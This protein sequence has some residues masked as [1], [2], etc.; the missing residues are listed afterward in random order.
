MYTDGGCHNTGDRK[1][2]GS[3][4]F[5]FYTDNTEY[6]DVYCEYVNDTTNNR[7]EMIAVIEGIKF[8]KRLSNKHQQV[9]IV[10]DSGY[11]VKGWTD[12][13][14]LDRW[15]TNN[16]KTSTNT[17]VQNRDLWMEL[18]RLSWHVGFNFIHIRGHN[19]D[20]NPEHA[21]WNDICDRAC[22][23]MINKI[24]NPGFMVTLRYYFK[25]RKFEPINIQL[26]ERR[27]NNVE[28]PKPTTQ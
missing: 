22:T 15:V 2:D 3:Y 26:I 10:S 6:V 16:W 7:M 21:F 28:Q 24:P 11:L 9:T 27:D 1:G 12:P 20:K 4:A 8:V 5:L 14:Y 17:P 23:H 19:K 18:Q 13:A 25:T